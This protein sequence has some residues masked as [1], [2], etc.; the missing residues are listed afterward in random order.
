MTGWIVLWT[1]AREPSAMLLHAA[2][3]RDTSGVSAL[4]FAELLSGLCAVV[5]LLIAAWLTATTALLIVVA[6]GEAVARSATSGGGRGTTLD[7]RL[8]ATRAFA[9][10]FSP[11]FTQR[12]VLTGCGLALGAG[13]GPGLA[14]TAAMARPESVEEP[15]AVSSVGV[16][17]L[18][19]PDRTFG[20]SP[21]RTF[22][23]PR[24]TR[25]AITTVEHGDSLW[26]LAAD[27][28]PA[29]ASDADITVA[30]HEL[31]RVNRDVI[32]ADPDLIFPGAT[33][34]VPPFAMPTG[35]ERP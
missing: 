10:R 19:L 12:L 9:C 33:L 14:N 11:R 3:T 30:W 7:G 24:P 4:P 22:I 27:L 34:Q 35:K 18:D 13:L 1:L 21:G 8:A 17:G 5:V 20:S 26:S 31:H 23:G 2:T 25:P 15:E 32:G 29:S 16:T 6:A 28:L